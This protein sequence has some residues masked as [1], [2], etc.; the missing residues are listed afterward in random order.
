MKL[1]QEITSS[2]KKIGLSL[3]GVAYHRTING[4]K[5]VV[6]DN[7]GEYDVVSL[8]ENNH[9]Y[10][11]QNGS[12]TFTEMEN[13]D[14]TL[15]I[16]KQNVSMIFVVSVHNRESLENIVTA[17]KGAI[18]E[19]KDFKSTLAAETWNKQEILDT[20]SLPENNLG[21]YKLIVNFSQN[22]VTDLCEQDLCLNFTNVC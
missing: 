1:K 16:M 2:L 12:V 20:E 15:T 19:I 7:N 10:F 8:N 21:M 11:R 9:G 17:L 14:C 3:T 4:R 22:F 13:V 18:Y 5:M 6:V